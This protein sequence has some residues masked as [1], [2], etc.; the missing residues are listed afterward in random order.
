MDHGSFETEREGCLWETRRGEEA[1]PKELGGEKGKGGK[2]GHGVLPLVAAVGW[3]EVVT[4]HRAPRSG[5]VTGYIG[6]GVG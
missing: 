2:E 1:G 4:S 3:E 5:L 6:R